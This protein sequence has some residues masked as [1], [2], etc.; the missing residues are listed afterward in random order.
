MYVADK[1]KVLWET[2]VG[3]KRK[4]TFYPSKKNKRKTNVKRKGSYLK[5]NYMRI[6]EALSDENVQVVTSSSEGDVESPMNTPEGYS[7]ESSVDEVGDTTQENNDGEGDS[8]VQKEFSAVDEFVKY[9]KESDLLD[10]LCK[11][12]YESDV[13][14]DFLNLMELSSMK[15]LPCDNI[16][17]VLLLERVKIQMCKSTVGM[18]YSEQTK[19]FGQ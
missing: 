15:A 14:F 10:N 8:S 6:T 5:P 7:V 17:F 13:L 11:V 12:L 9:V 2:S 18:R 19:S 3:R 16:V 1:N 4:L